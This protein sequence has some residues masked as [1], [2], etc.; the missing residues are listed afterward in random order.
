MFTKFLFNVCLISAIFG[1][2]IN[3]CFSQREVFIH[4]TDSILN[5]DGNL[6]EPVWKNAEICHSF[7]QSSPNAGAPSKYRTEIKMVYNDHSIYFGISCFAPKDDLSCVL[8]VRDD[9]NS[10][11]DYVAIL[12]DTYNDDQNGFV[13]A[14]SSRGVQFDGKVFT[15]D[16]YSELNLA[17]NSATRI[18]DS[19]WIAEIKIPYSALRFPKIDEQNWGVNFIRYVASKRE[20]SAWNPMRPDFDN[21]M[22]QCGNLKGLKSINPPLRLSFSPYV[23]GYIEHSPKYL[24][25]EKPWSYTANGGMDLKYGINEAFTIDMT[26]V[27]DFGQVQFDNQVLNLSPFEVRFNDYRP[28]FTEGTELFNKADLFYS[29]RIGSFPINYSTPYENL[30]SNEQV[31]QNPTIP[32]LLN[33]IKFSGRTKKGLGIGVFNAISAESYAVIQDSISSKKRKVLTSPLTNYNV[34][35]F[36]QNLKNNSYINFT[37]TNVSR[38]GHTYDANVSSFMGKLNT[39][40]NKYYVFGKGVVSQLYFTDS[41]SLGHNIQLELGK[42]RGQFTY[43]FGYSEQ[44][45]TYDPNDLGFIYNNNIQQATTNLRYNIYTPFWRLNRLWSGVNLNYSRLYSPNS[46]VAFNTSGNIGVTDKRFHTY[47]FDFEFRP[48]KH[49]DFFEPRIIGQYFIRPIY[50]SSGFWVSTNYQKK[51]ALDASIY[52]TD[53]AGSAW[54]TLYINLSPRWRINNTMFLTLSVDN[55]F[56]NAERGKAIP[57]QYLASAPSINIFGS[58]SGHTTVNTINYTFTLTNRSGISFRLRHYWA[59]IH[60]KSFYQL[61]ANGSLSGLDYAGTDTLGNSLYNTNFNAFTIDFVYRWIF[62]PASELNIVWKNAIFKSDDKTA[63]NYFQNLNALFDYGAINSVSLRV[64][65]YLD[66]GNIKRKST[67]KG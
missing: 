8:S 17:W 42:Q 16:W 45:D 3:V 6:N 46:F 49:V 21:D 18:T 11:I 19:C 50:F 53:I 40:S 58:R 2:K 27:P 52:Y 61:N 12:L 65:Y 14:V 5:V 38:S 33:A 25:A 54:N 10:T 15:S 55:Q 56:T 62:A 23:S 7:T 63:L 13:F 32:Q 24:M 31:I 9:L 41:L 59:S 30:D 20:T 44:S 22:A 57:N 66:A 39:N 64:V 43:S 28:F 35:V 34:A 26:L 1:W 36:D 47:G 60:Y 67:K 29:R 37:N 48:T 51:L 4:K